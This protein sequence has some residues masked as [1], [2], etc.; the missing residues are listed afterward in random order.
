MSNLI[1]VVSVADWR[2]AI[3]AM[4]D[5]E[6]RETVDFFLSYK[7]APEIEVNV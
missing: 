4:S 6:F 2:L 3:R 1:K 5:A 7:P